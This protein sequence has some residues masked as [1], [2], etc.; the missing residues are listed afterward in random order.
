MSD[1][2]LVVDGSI[3][4][5]A[6]DCESAAIYLGNLSPRTLRNWR[7]RGVG[8]VYLRIGGRVVYRVSD[9]DAWLASHAVGGDL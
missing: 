4:P 3:S 1:Q 6:V 9:L 5:A 2:T 8:P 7:N